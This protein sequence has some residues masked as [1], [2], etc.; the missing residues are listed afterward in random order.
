MDG[1]Q[2]LQWYD[3]PPKLIVD[4]VLGAVGMGGMDSH[5]ATLFVSLLLGF[6]TVSLPFWFAG[7][8]DKAR[9]SMITP[10]VGINILCKHACDDFE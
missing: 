8:P 7:S 6:A 1:V 10:P 3:L 4:A 5:T 2:I 9:K